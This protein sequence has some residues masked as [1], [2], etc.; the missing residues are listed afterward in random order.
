MSHTESYS[1]ELLAWG[2]NTAVEVPDE[3]LER[4]GKGKRPGVIVTLNGYEYRS[5]VAVMDGMT[6]LPVAKKIRD[7]AGVAPGDLIAVTL[8]LEVGP[9]P[10]DLP[11]D[12]AA[13]LDAQPAAREFYDNLANS[14][15]RFHADNVNGAKTPKTR[16]RR[17]EKSVALFLEGKKR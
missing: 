6:L 10:V 3:V 12:L 13:A 9:R 4:F 17:I 14:L 15:Q 7:G 11:D 5:T 1:T 16:Q 8:T 2:N